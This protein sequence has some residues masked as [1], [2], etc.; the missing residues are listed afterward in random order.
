GDPAVGGALAPHTDAQPTTDSSDA[1]AAWRAVLDALGY[2]TCVVDG[3][4]RVVHAN[5]EAV[6]LLEVDPC[7]RRLWD[8]VRIVGQPGRGAG[9]VLAPLG[10][11]D[12]RAT[13]DDGCWH[14][15]DDVL[16]IVPGG[17]AFPGRCVLAPASMPDG[18]TVA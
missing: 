17:R 16:V 7:G 12:V 6:R 4:G 2:G 9:A 5:A 1:A 3:A 10:R 15:R 14:R 11:E 18:T 13:V 8:V